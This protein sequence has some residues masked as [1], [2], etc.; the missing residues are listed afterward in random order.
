MVDFNS[1]SINLCAS[2]HDHNEHFSP[3]FINIETCTYAF[4]EMKAEVVELFLRVVNIDH[5]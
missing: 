1:M 2:Y 4:E 5:E 3:K